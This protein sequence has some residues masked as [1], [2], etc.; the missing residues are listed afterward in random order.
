MREDSL[1]SALSR[2][3]PRNPHR[4]EVKNHQK[5]GIP[6]SKSAHEKG[7][8]SREGGRANNKQAQTAWEL[9]LR[10]GGHGSAGPATGRRTTTPTGRSPTQSQRDFHLN[11]QPSSI[12]QGH[13][14]QECLVQANQRRENAPSRQEAPT[15]E[16]CWPRMPVLTALV[17]AP[18]P[19]PLLPGTRLQECSG[20]VS[21][22]R[23]WALGWP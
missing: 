8:P 20:G 11:P 7:R 13:Y 19:P 2:V 9:G 15:S 6:A 10:R 1:H 3:A 5:E 18:P 4:M 12:K 17:G 16:L 23:E 22:L 21:G 14:H